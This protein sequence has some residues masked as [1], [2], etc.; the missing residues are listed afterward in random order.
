MRFLKPLGALEHAASEHGINPQ[1]IEEAEEDVGYV[2]KR[3]KGRKNRRHY[4]FFAGTSSRYIVVYLI[5][6]TAEYEMQ[7][8]RPM[9]PDEVDE[10]HRKSRTRRNHETKK[11]I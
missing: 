9:D 3:G 7:S 10:Y 8:A 4:F 11:K 5:L 2:L 6:K 1:E